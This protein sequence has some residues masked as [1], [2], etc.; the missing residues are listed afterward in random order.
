MNAFFTHQQ[1]FDRL[2]PEGLPLPNVTLLGCIGE[3]SIPFFGNIVVASWLRQGGSVVFLS[4]KNLDFNVLSQTI[5]NST[6][7]DL[8]YHKDRIAFIELD[9]TL[10]QM[11][12]I[13]ENSFRANLLKTDVWYEAIVRASNLVP[14]EDPGI[15]IYCYD[16]NLQSLTLKTCKL[17]IEKMKEVG[18]NKNLSFLISV[19]ITGKNDQLIKLETTADNFVL[20]HNNKAPHGNFI[21]IKRIKNAP[22]L[23]DKVQ[24]PINSE[25]T[26]EIKSNGRISINQLIPI[27]L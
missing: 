5:K 17:I 19:N 13:T 12:P 2:L 26:S 24:M 1:W 23:K 11:S 3:K 10:N 27:I 22:F 14:Y 16:I 6:K 4:L 21:Q 9:P 18:T 20:N 8:A 15:L 25:S 7:L